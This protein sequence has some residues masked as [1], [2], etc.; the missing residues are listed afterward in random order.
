M[1][2]SFVLVDH[3]PPHT[4]RIHVH[5]ELHNGTLF[6]NRVFAD[7][8]QEHILRWDCHG[9]GWALNPITR[10]ADKTEERTCENGERGRSDTNTWLKRQGRIFPESSEGAWPCWHFCFSSLTSGGGE[11]KRE[12]ENFPCFKL[13]VCSNLQKQLQESNR[14]LIPVA[15]ACNPIYSGGRGQEDCGSKPAPANSSR[16]P[17]WKM[18]NTKQGWWEWLKW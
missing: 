18:A 10:K 7:L 1:S 6:G 12:R 2:K 14:S 15:H 4:P 17:M 11:R 16:G 13:P 8:I 5:L 9:L 3:R